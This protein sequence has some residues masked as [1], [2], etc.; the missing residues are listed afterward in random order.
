MST[1]IKKIDLISASMQQASESI[2]EV[3]GQVANSSVEQAGQTD[4]VVMSLEENINALGKI[5]SR[6]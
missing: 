3:V 4:E 5:V 6:K 2:D 1:F